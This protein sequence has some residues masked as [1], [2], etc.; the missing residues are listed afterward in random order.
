MT[1]VFAARRRAEE[2]A[3]LVEEPS[4]PGADES[5]YADLLTVVASMRETPAP[6]ARPEFVSAL[7]ERLMAEAP[8]ALASED[9][10]RL[11]L[12]PRDRRRERRI[13]A[14]VGGI[15]IAGASTSMALASQN[16]LPGDALYPVK[17]AI[18]DVHTGFS[19]GE[20]QKGS[21]MLANARGR[22]DEVSELSRGGDLGDDL[23]IADTLNDFT[24]QAA[25]ASDLLIADYQQSGD[26]ASVEELRDFTA[27]SL[28]QLTELE[29]VVPDPARDELMHAAQVLISIDTAA[30]QACPACDDGGITRIPPMF[31]PASS[32]S[33]LVSSAQGEGQ[34]QA[35]GGDGKR[36]DQQQD[37]PSLPVVGELELP[38]GSLLNPGDGTQSGQQPG[39]P[40]DPVGSLT[41][42]LTGGGSEPT[43]NPQLPDVDGTVDDVTD[44]VG[45]LLDST[46]DTVTGQLP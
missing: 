34:H 38:P 29:E 16:A 24:D 3:A 39:T 37:E 43:S 9:A 26:E 10:A 12:P 45:D 21:T 40:D 42:D 44:G 25:Q 18:E 19:V 33:D 31:S 17:R 6:T 23:A 15:A 27:T 13:A 35:D 28:D 11:S 8:A 7:R 2:F 5:R 36:G 46:T 41:D 1:P 4:T 20:A 30:Q 22:L 14:V 32:V